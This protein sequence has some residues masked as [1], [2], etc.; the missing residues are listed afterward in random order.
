M[1]LGLSKNEIYSISRRIVPTVDKH[2]A[3]EMARY[4]GLF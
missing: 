4:V 2:N 3:P 1:A